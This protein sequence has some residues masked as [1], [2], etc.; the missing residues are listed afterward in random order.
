[1]YGVSEELKAEL[2]KEMGTTRNVNRLS[3]I[4]R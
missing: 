1:V 3:D 2:L 4:N